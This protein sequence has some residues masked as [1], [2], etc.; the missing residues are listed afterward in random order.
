[1]ESSSKNDIY[2]AIQQLIVGLLTYLSIFVGSLFLSRVMGPTI[3][4]NYNIAIAVLSIFTTIVL[5]GTDTASNR[6]IPRSRD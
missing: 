2:Q 6:F 5:L 1:M 3:F 4:G